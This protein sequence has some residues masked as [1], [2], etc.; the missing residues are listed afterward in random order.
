MNMRGRAEFVA[1]LGEIFTITRLR[2]GA[3][4]GG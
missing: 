4:L 2:L 1:A 3:L